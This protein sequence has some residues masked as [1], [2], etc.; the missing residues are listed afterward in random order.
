MVTCDTPGCRQAVIDGVTGFS[1]PPR[2]PEALARA[3]GRLMEAPELRERMGT[4]G[5]KL[6]TERF[7]IRKI[8]ELHLDVYRSL[9]LNL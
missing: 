1:V 3:V 2:D 5:R 4:A 9:G 8:T 6:A 7:D